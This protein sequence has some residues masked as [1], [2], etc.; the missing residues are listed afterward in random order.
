MLLVA[1][2]QFLSALDPIFKFLYGQ[3][4]SEDPEELRKSPRNEL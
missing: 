3:V 1:S 4:N 2:F